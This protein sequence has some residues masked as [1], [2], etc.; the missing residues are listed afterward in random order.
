LQCSI[1]YYVAL[2]SDALGIFNRL[3]L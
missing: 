1:H 2:N 3:A